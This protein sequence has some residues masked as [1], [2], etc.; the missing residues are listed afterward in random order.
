[1]Y[2]CV[3]KAVTD[4]RIVRSVDEGVRRL[5]DLKEMTGLGSCCGKCVP[6]ARRLLTDALA[7][8]SAHQPFQPFSA[9][10]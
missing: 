6:D 2:I 10:A 7:R 9:A 4:K 8:Q 5:K 3:C 1:M